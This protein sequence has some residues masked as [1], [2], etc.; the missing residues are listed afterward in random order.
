MA[1]YRRSTW[2]DAPLEMV[3]EAH[4]SIDGLLAIT[5]S[6]L[7]LTVEELR[8]ENGEPVDLD[9]ELQ[10]GYEVDLSVRPFGVDPGQT[11][12]S[13]IAARERRSESDAGDS[14]SGDTAMFRDRMIRG[15][16]AHWEHTHHFEA[17]DGGT[18]L[19]DLVEYQLAPGGL[20]RAVSVLGP[21]GLAPA[22]WYR[23]RTTRRRFEGATN[24][25]NTPG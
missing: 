10:T 21:L 20:G 15:P 25:G 14:A 12:T 17:V 5:P 13:R 1:R 9:A 23:H 22:F 6:W 4:A 16:M 11:W 18:R 2:V 8:D 24:D 7:G 19:T 3:W